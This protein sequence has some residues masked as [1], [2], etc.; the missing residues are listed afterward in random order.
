MPREDLAPEHE[1]K[2]VFVL[3]DA[4]TL[5]AGFSVVVEFWR[6]GATTVGTPP[7]QA[8]SSYGAAA[9]FKLR[10]TGLQGMVPMISAGHGRP[11]HARHALRAWAPSD[12]RCTTCAD[13]TV[14]CALGFD[15]RARARDLARLLSA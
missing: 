7:A 4:G 9:V 2:R 12:I 5:S 10:H 1:P 11:Q 6:L 8:P 15:V 13:C 3:C 14:R